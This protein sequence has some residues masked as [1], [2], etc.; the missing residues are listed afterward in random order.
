MLELDISS[1]FYK[2]EFHQLG[3]GFRI[4]HSLEKP[5]IIEVLDNGL[6]RYIPRILKSG[7]SGFL[8]HEKWCILCHVYSILSILC[9]VSCTRTEY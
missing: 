7:V 4:Y 9:H 2:F 6:F 5:E 3:Y 1:I 8:D